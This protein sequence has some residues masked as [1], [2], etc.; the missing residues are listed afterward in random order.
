MTADLASVRIAAAADAVYGFVSDPARLN[1]WS[2]G[3]WRTV[4]HGDGLVEGWAMATGAR[5]LVQFDPCPGR[6]M[7][8]YRIGPTPDALT[9]RIFARVIAGETTGH[10]PGSCLLLLGA[11][12]TTEMEQDRWDR[13]IRTHAFEVDLVKALIES[14]HDHRNWASGADRPD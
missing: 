14:G 12:R 7:V 11:L 2:V 13:M 3:T 1:L 5:I 8:D 9:P 4:L 10:G 6:R